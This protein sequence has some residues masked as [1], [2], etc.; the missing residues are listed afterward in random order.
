MPEAY[1]A[2]STKGY[3]WGTGKTRAYVS[4]N[5]VD[6]GND[7]VTVT[8]QGAV[9]SVAPYSMNQYGVMVQ[10][11]HG[12]GDGAGAS[13]VESG[14]VIRY[15]NWV[16]WPS[17]SATFAKRTTNYNVTVWTKYW[18]QTVSGYG[19]CS[20]TGELYM[21]VTIPARPLRPP[22][23]PSGLIAVR[24]AGGSIN[25]S[26]RNNASNAASTIVERMPRGGSWAVVLDQGAV[27]TTY[28]DSVSSGTYKY[29]VRYWNPDGLSGYSNES[30]WVTSLCAPAAPTL[31]TPASGATVSALGGKATLSWRHN[32]LDTSPQMGAMV[33]WSFDGGATWTTGNPGLDASGSSA[34]NLQID[35]QPNSDVRWQVRTRGA[36]SGGSVDFEEYSPWSAVSM[37]K[38]RT[39][40]SASVSVDPVV[41]TVPIEV[42][43][44]YDDAMGTQAS[45]LVEVVDAAGST[46]FSKSV[47]L[48][49]SY[50]IQAAEFTPEHGASYRVRLSVTST[51]SLSHVSEAS[52]SVDYVPPA[53]PALAVAVDDARAAAVVTVMDGLP[54]G[55]TPSAVRIV[56]FR[57]SV[58]V[59]EVVPGASV[60]DDL[61]PLDKEIVYRAVAYAASGSAS[62]SVERVV[63]SSHGAVF[64]NFG[65]DVALLS[66]NLSSSDDYEAQREFYEVASAARPKVFYGRAGERTGEHSATVFRTQDLFG[67]GEG[68]LLPAIERLQQYNGM[69]CMRMPGRE[70]I[71][72]DA[73]VRVSFSENDSKTAAVSVSW[74]EVDRR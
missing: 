58:A 22:S 15:A 68:A 64:F 8:V 40:P 61:P 47:G 4:A 5:V 30:D 29:R 2:E 11:G 33:R 16:G 18:G 34:S 53:R 62:E 69:S 73:V 23:A 19:A 72:V 44:T 66:T 70:P 71:W 36:F 20:N 74:R 52:F 25:V 63:V 13:W 14:G 17:V 27:L 7:T 39:P 54:A 45:A 48:A 42:S 51:T 56:L 46:V 35:V 37:F 6:N 43:W 21:D 59:G 41:R 24:G 65:Q 57:N 32:S 10:A 49:K 31:V 55:D 1:G 9:Q 60:R 26:W 12:G 3:S 28:T 67:R 38:V 50:T